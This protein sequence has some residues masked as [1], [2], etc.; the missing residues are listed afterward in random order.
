MQTDWG[1]NTPRCPCWADP[2]HTKLVKLGVPDSSLP[3]LG[4]RPQKPVTLLKELGAKACETM[5]PAGHWVGSSSLHLAWGPVRRGAA[6]LSPLE[7]LISPASLGL[8][9]SALLA[10]ALVLRPHPV[11][12][13]LCLCGAGHSHSHINTRQQGARVR[14]HHWS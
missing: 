5:P 3:S 2:G 10:S 8:P 14:P 13:N 6:V 7:A 1:G 4:R 12:A 9:W 11:T